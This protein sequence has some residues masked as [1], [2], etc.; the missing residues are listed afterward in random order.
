VR[1]ILLDP[2]ARGDL[3]TDPNYGRLREPAQFIAGVCR[4]FDPKGIG[5][6]INNLVESD[7]YLNPQAILM[8]QDLLR[9][10]TVFGYFPSEYAVP[11][12]NL[13]GPEFGA[14]SATTYTKRVNFV[15]R[16][17]YRGIS[18]GETEDTVNGT[19]IN[20]SAF[21]PLASD[22]PQLIDKLD[23]LFL[24]GTMTPA[25]RA[26]ILEA[27]NAVPTSDRNFQR[28]RTQA[29][30]FLVLSSPQYQVQR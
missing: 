3:K 17:A 16:M 13:K 21:M 4:P 6:G 2:E 19:L 10:A 7:G 5:P 9:P 1:A 23:A 30:V 27:L 14:L 12:T 26:A 20:F 24:H 18:R 22:P 11:R 28:N 15:A 8:G 25:T 29:A